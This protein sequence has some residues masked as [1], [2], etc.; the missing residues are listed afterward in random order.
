[1][2]QHREPTPVHGCRPAPSLSAAAYQAGSA[3]LATISHEL[4]T[5]LNAIIGLSELLQQDAQ[6]L[7]EQRFVG[8]LLAINI[9]SHDLLGLID[10]VLDFLSLDAGQMKPY[11]ES[12]DVAALVGDVV[13]VAEPLV[14]RNANVLRVVCAPHL[15]NM[16]ADLTMIRKTLL[17]LLSNAAK[18]TDHGVVELRVA[19]DQ[20]RGVREDGHSS[21]VTFAISDNGVGMTPEQVSRL[22]TPFFQGD[23]STTSRCGD[24]GL[25]LAISHR[26]CEMMGGEISVE[27]EAGHGSIFTVR[28]PADVEAP[29]PAGAGV[30]AG[31]VPC[32]VLSGC[33]GAPDH[34]R[35]N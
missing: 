34:T 21:L 11:L 29:G 15:G 26:F 35:I 2:V 32:A 22:F 28:F 4:R 13:A 31:S 18:F 9:A 8:D 12:F 23:V 27:S 25:G 6:E 16:R 14:A 33:H 10:A 5:P 19:R 1:M 30:A 17:H 20:R 7:G 3:F 24:I